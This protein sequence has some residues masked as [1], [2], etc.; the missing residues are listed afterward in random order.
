MYI[1]YEYIIIIIIIVIIYIYLYY[2]YHFHSFS[3]NLTGQWLFVLRLPKG[4]LRG[5]INEKDAP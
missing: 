4:A 1:Y 5:S 3:G 2:M